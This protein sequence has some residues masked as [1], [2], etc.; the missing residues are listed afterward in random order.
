MRPPNEKATAGRQVALN[1]TGRQPNHTDRI[2]AAQHIRD[3]A[4]LCFQSACQDSPLVKTLEG[5]DQK[6]AGLHILKTCKAAHINSTVAIAVE[7]RYDVRIPAAAW[8][9]MEGR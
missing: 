2:T 1:T 9:A 6:L 5:I 7:G 3:N 4:A 8:R